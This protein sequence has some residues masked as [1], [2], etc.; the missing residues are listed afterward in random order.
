M[1]APDTKQEGSDMAED[2]S[3]EYAELMPV[4]MDFVS[5]LW[6]S[7][8]SVVYCAE[9]FYLLRIWNVASWISGTELPT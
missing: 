5:T 4:Q 8:L 9:R 3:K 7:I 2:I 1:K 6:H